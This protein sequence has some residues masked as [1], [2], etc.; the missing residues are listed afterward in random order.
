MKIFQSG[1]ALLSLMC[2][3][4]VSTLF[5]AFVGEYVCAGELVVKATTIGMTIQGEYSPTS[6][7]SCNECGRDCS[8]VCLCFLDKLNAVTEFCEECGTTALAPRIDV[9]LYSMPCPPDIY[10]VQFVHFNLSRP[11]MAGTQTLSTTK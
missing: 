9:T 1:A 7:P 6:F 3:I 5:E 11:Q 2:A 8:F 10:M 4:S